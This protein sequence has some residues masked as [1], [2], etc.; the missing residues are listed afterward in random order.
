M[1]D[2]ER[3]NDL[4]CLVLLTGKVLFC[5]IINMSSATVRTAEFPPHLLLLPLPCAA[6]DAK[7]SLAYT[8]G[9][10]SAPHCPARPSRTTEGPILYG[11]RLPGGAL[12]VRMSRTQP[13]VGQ[14]LTAA[15]REGDGPAVAESVLDDKVPHYEVVLVSVDADIAAA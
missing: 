15:A 4:S 3:N 11:K 6:P 2:N 5:L 10:F 1:S 12:F 9:P 8:T 7:T 13:L 14:A